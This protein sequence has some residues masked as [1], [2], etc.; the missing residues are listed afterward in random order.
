MN[1]FYLHENPEICAEYHCDK[2][3]VKMILETAQMLSTA[4]R[5]IDGDKWANDVGLYKM[6]HKNH[7]STKWVRENSQNYRWAYQ[8]F[9]EL[10]Q[11]YTIRYGKHHASERLLHPLK[12]VPH[13]IKQA[14]KTTEPPQCMPDVYKGEDTVLAYRN[15]YMYEK[16]SFAVWKIQEPDW[17]K[18]EEYAR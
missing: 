12:K 9:D 8:L 4:H 10:L 13:F 14:N 7:P 3:V 2:H 6:D 17:W 15:Y 18:I 16:G 1:I 5:I 11:Q